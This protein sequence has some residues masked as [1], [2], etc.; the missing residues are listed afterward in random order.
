MGWH[1]SLVLAAFG[2]WISFGQALAA[3]IATQPRGDGGLHIV[4][5]SGPLQRGDSQKFFEHT[6]PLSRAVVVLRSPGGLLD[7]GLAIGEQIRQKGFASAVA[8][9]TLCASACAL[10]WLGGRPRLMKETSRIGFHAAY[11]QGGSYKRE[12]GVGNAVVGAY[13]TDMGFNLSVVRYV[14]TPGLEEIQWL[15]TRDA[16]RLGIAVYSYEDT[17]LASHSVAPAISTESGG[18]PTALRAV[19]NFYPRFKSTGMAGMSESVAACYKRA[20]ALRTIASV[21]YCFTIDLLAVDLSIWGEKTFKFPILPYF[22]ASQASNRTQ[23]LLASLGVVNDA[24]QL[25]SQWQDYM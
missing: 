4:L 3:E 2:Y 13:L 9:S 5:I 14:T 17:L 16:I 7:E 20:A 22:T 21:Q 25:L 1:G 8:E 6:K 19:N 11:V 15:S 23:E 24:G 10:A 12:I 18:F